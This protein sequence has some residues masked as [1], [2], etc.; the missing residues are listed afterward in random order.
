LHWLLESAYLSFNNIFSLP[1]K[2]NL[3]LNASVYSGGHKNIYYYKSNG[4]VQAGLSK[5]I[6]IKNLTASIWLVDVFKTDT[7]NYISNISNI[8]R[9]INSYNGE[10]MLMFS[11]HYTFN[12]AESRYK[13]SRSGIEEKQRL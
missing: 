6:F 13:S 11:I 7:E 5:E 2:F 12:N 10:R 3:Y 8:R 4:N 9:K 1:H